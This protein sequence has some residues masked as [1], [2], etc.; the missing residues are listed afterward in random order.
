MC[1]RPALVSE[2]YEEPLGLLQSPEL[3]RAEGDGSLGKAAVDLDAVGL[4]GEG[5]HSW[6]RRQT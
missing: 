1:T 6:W 2:S 5:R 3:L 4:Q